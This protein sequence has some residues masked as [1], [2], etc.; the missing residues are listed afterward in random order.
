MRQWVHDGWLAFTAC[1]LSFAPAVSQAAR[2]KTETYG[3][4][5]VVG[6]NVSQL[7]LG[8]RDGAEP[9]DLL[10]PQKLLE[11]RLRA[12]AVLKWRKLEFDVELDA[13]NGLV[14]TPVE[15]LL[16]PLSAEG[17]PTRADVIDPV[18]GRRYGTDLNSLALRKASLIWH[19]DIGQ[20]AIGATTN[21]FGMGLLAN[22]GAGPLDGQLADQRF[23]DRVLRASY[24]TKPL[25]YLSK[26]R[27]EEDVTSLVGLD[28]LLG[29]ETATLV[30]P[31]TEWSQKGLIKDRG[32]Q[33]VLALKHRRGGYGSGLFY[34]HRR[35]TTDGSAGLDPIVTSSFDAGLDVDIL[36]LFVE[37][38][39]GLA[40]GS[41]WNVAAEG[42][43]VTGDANLVR[44]AACPGRGASDRCTVQQGGAI[45]RGGYS[46]GALSLDL[47]GGYASGDGN[48]FDAKLTNFRFDRDFKV[49][50]VLFDQVMAWQTA[51]MV[52]R[53]GDP[54]LANV[55][56][57]GLE[58]LSTSGA[59]TNALFV[60]PQLRWQ[61][62]GHTKL[63]A[64]AL[65]AKSAQG[66]FDPLWSN[67]TSS[68]TGPFGQP[69][70]RNYGVEFD[71][72]LDDTRALDAKRQLVWGIAAGHFLPGD[73]FATD[74]SG[75]T[76]A[77]VTLVKA[78][79]AVLF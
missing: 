14:N 58:L 48:P 26:G 40:G 56:T 52:R 37:Y 55:P 68:L 25:Y 8:R 41:A 18:R 6:T 65:W 47:L 77:P 27:I 3:S 60:Q 30:R 4:W 32:L 35:L 57:A 51:A 59:V 75:H 19:S 46:Q 49:G 17:A 43:F 9:L 74:A 54:S 36:D 31:A 78:R 66:V 79:A 38:K 61:L 7:E 50:L 21:H 72:G 20:F 29:D 70:G 2:L 45:A 42:A 69:A 33:F 5:R 28:L 73:A 53:A 76:I 71:L 22:D 11:H 44:N 62:A 24:A 39:R 63:T 13:L 10:G 12:G 16:P 34:A 67:R 1:A 15:G 23:G 64:S